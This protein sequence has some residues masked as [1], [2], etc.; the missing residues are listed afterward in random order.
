MSRGARAVVDLRDVCLGRGDT[1]ILDGLTWS[2]DAGERWVVLGP[3]GAG[4]TTLLQVVTAYAHPSSGTA[5][6]LGHRL[7]AVDVRWLRRKIA[8]ASGSLTRTLDT[9]LTAREIVTTGRSA[10]LA[11]WWDEPDAS[12]DAEVDDLLAAAG[13]AAAADRPF[14]ALSE[15][16]RQRALLARMRASRA[17]LWVFDEPAAGLD[18]GARERLVAD[19]AAMAAAPAEGSPAIVFV[20]HHVEEIPPGFG[21]ALLLRGGRAVAAGAIDDV[22]T[23][24]HLSACFDLPLIVEHRD[25]R[26]SARAAVP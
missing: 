26:W 9:R 21:H 3:N 25:G 13:L 24:E 2:V 22:L 23:S 4:K 18:L 11:P 19:L 8:V 20:T 16:E 1:V 6:I 15:G 17:D 12:L 5:A 10:S 7:G 14:S